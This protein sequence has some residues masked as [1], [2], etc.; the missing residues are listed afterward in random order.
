F[1]AGVFNIGGSGQFIFGAVI[2]FV[3]APLLGPLPMPLGLIVYLGIGFVGGGLL[4]L[5]V[6]WL[7]VRFRASEIISTIVL[8]FIVLQFLSWLIRGPLQE[9][10]RLMPW[11]DYLPETLLLPN[12]IAGSRVHYGLVVAIIAVA[13]QI[14]RA[15]CREREEI[16]VYEE[17]VKREVEAERTD[18]TIDKLK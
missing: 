15:S 18:A 5:F 14:G 3:C 7:R 2:S 4:G 8:N 13:V 16:S 9:P 1:R 6:G 11:S 10:S 12:L 17:A